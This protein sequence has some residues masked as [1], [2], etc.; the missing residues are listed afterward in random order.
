MRKCIIMELKKAFFQKTM[1]VVLAL[2]LLLVILQEE[3]QLE[4]VYS[5]YGIRGQEI[6]S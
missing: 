5:V 4:S 3:K 6:H 2:L 1:A